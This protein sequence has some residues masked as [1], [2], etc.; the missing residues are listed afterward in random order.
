MVDRDSLKEGSERREGV[1]LKW[2]RRG[3][4]K[5]STVSSRK[6]IDIFEVFSF[7]KNFTKVRLMNYVKST[8]ND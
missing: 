6:R 8:S 5:P 7:S 2:T 4:I 1:V 3:S